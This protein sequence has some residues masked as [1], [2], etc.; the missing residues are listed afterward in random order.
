MIK[1]K[2]KAE[3]EKH[4]CRTCHGL[5]TYVLP[6][7]A[8]LAIQFLARESIKLAQYAFTID[9]SDMGGDMPDIYVM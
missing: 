1:I 8:A 2:A 5:Y 9:L 7:V 3:T 6:G 4:T